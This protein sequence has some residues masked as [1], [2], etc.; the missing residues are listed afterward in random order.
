M[1]PLITS[2]QNP[3]IKSILSLDKARERKNQ[4]VFVIE[5]IRELSLALE[6]GYSIKSIYFCPSIISED[7]VVK[8]VNNANVLV[9]V[10]KSVFEK[11]AYRETTGGIIAVAEQR[12]H[13]LSGIK[14]TANP[15]LLVVESVE[16][17]GNLG[18]LLRTADAAGLDAVIICDPQTDFY[19]PN[20]IRSSVG[21]VFTNQIASA[22]SDE[23]I[24]WLRENHIA[25][26][27]TYLQAS[28]PYH[29][30]DFSKACAIIMGTEATG[31]SDAWIK[32]AAANIIIPMQGKIDSM[33]VSTAAAV[34]IFEAKRQRN[35][36]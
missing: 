5:G 26:Y 2:H 22:S 23:T 4:N 19:N 36:Q 12:K 28:N 3:K 11:I 34:V 35:F 16:K 14:L 8:L 17:P 33:N 18:A 13:T 29:L 24:Q 25:I 6:G 10:D 7:Q 15:L 9:P 32:S 1:H 21:C 31:L 30:T 20:V 27:C